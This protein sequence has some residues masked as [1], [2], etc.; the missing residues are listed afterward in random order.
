MTSCYRTTLPRA[1]MR[2]IANFSLDYKSSYYCPC[3]EMKHLK[4]LPCLVW[5]TLDRWK[6][7]YLRGSNEVTVEPDTAAGEAS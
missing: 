7:A 3:E 1:F 5:P 6:W 2:G 4:N